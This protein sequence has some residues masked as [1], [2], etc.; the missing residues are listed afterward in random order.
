MTPDTGWD[1]DLIILSKT[2]EKIGYFKSAI[3]AREIQNLISSDQHEKIIELYEKMKDPKN[4]KQHITLNVSFQDFSEKYMTPIEQQMKYWIRKFYGSNSEK[5][6]KWCK[7]ANVHYDDIISEYNK[8][9]SESDDV[10]DSLMFG[11]CVYIIVGTIF[12]SEFEYRKTKKDFVYNTIKNRL[13]ELLGTRNKL[14]HP[15]TT[16]TGFEKLTDAEKNLAMI[17]C[18]ECIDFFKKD[19]SK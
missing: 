4:L 7:E 16:K 8:K 14:S 2:Y 6:E 19:L 17:Y 10:Y 9:K 12:H 11:N 3:K 5:F 18:I 15:S 13:F 1:T